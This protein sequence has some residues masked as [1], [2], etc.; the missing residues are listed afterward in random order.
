MRYSWNWGSALFG[1]AGIV[2]AAGCA[3]SHTFKVDAISNPEVEKVGSYHIVTGNSRIAEEDP[4][5][6][7]MAAY[8]KTALSGKGY[9]EAPN[10]EEAELVIEVDYGTN[11][12]QIDFKTGAGDSG[13]GLDRTGRT[14]TGRSRNVSIERDETEYIPVT[15]YEKYL[16]LIAWENQDGVEPEDQTQVWQVTVKTKDD[17]D[18]MEKYLPLLA[19]ASIAYMGEDTESQEK[20]VLKETDDDVVF[21]KKGM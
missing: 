17:Q 13:R 20:I 8:V 18:D 1:A 15:T 14:Y 3:T 9:H 7:E 2:F 11:R 16:K 12:P 21:V 19:A 6:Q 5:F 10:A 4:Q